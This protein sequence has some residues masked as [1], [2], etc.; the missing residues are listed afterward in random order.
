M[1][2]RP[3]SGCVALNFTQ[4]HCL[5]DMTDFF[6]LYPGW[7]EGQIR[8]AG[9]QTPILAGVLLWSNQATWLGLDIAKSGVL[10]P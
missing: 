9:R 4:F 8:T 2:W 1:P 6:F 5:L 10:S 7:A 3:V